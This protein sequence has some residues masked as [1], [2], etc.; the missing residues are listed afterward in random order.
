M[1]DA[2]KKSKMAEEVVSKR[3]PAAESVAPLRRLWRG[4]TSSA[5]ARLPVAERVGPPPRR[6]FSVVLR[7]A[8]ASRSGVER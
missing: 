5:T 3:L 6:G 4:L 1:A 2:S 7:A 8:A